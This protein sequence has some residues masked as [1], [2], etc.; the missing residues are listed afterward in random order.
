[1]ANSVQTIKVRV[2]GAGT[3]WNLRILSV[4]AKILGIRLRVEVET[5]K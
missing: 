5:K 4:V 2:V 1:M 3:K